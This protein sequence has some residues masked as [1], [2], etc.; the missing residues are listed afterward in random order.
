[1]GRILVHGVW[2]D[3]LA[4]A[5]LYEVEY[6]RIVVDHAPSLFP[7]FRVVPFKCT[8]EAEDE[9]SKQPDLALISHDYRDWWVVEVELA[10]HDFDG[11]VLPQVRTLARGIYGD[12]HAAHLC[13]KAPDL[14]RERIESMMKGRQPKVLVVLNAP[15]P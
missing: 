3:Q 11:H 9:D 1:M 5:A 15:R 7:Q 14:D 4:D 8:V 2:Y 6:E 10:H 12:S 13:R